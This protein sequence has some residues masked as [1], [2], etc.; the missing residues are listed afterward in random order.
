MN[1]KQFLFLV[2]LYCALHLVT[3]YL[4]WCDR[5]HW[6]AAR[7]TFT[8]RFDDDGVYHA[9]ALTPALVA[10]CIAIWVVGGITLGIAGGLWVW[11]KLE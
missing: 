4:Q 8:L 9:N 3:C 10:M 6:R 7:Q 2:A 5:Q 11:W 1:V